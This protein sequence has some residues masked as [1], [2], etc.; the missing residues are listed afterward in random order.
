MA[1]HPKDFDCMEATILDLIPVRRGHFVLESGHHG[2]LWLDLDSLFLRPAKLQP[3][4]RELARRL[5]AHGVEAIVGPLVGGA[6]VA[7]VVAAELD[8][9]FAFAAR[10]A[11]A[12]GV[13]YVIPE[14]VHHHLR[15]RSVAVVDDAINAGSAT[16]ATVAALTAMGTRPVAVGALLT[17]GETALPHFAASGLPVET[18][19]RLPNVLWEAAHC[20]L[21][22]AGEP[23]SNSADGP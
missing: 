7:Q 9:R 23:L 3:L 19:A 2:D 12:R 10:R 5:A 18:L 8:V 20:P 11:S 15:D 22:A 4:T 14:S 21:C 13:D 6:L 17:L 16:R 1:H